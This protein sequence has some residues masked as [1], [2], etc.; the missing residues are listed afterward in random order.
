M[1]EIKVFE[2][3]NQCQFY[4]ESFIILYFKDKS[5]INEKNRGNGKK[6]FVNVEKSHGEFVAQISP[7]QA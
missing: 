1:H 6:C 3:K 4:F 2:D 5:L 7:A